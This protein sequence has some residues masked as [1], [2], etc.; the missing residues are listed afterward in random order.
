[1]KKSLAS[2]LFFVAAVGMIAYAMMMNPP[3]GVRGGAFIADQASMLRKFLFLAYTYVWPAVLSFCA[4]SMFQ[5]QFRLSSSGA[6]GRLVFSVCVLASGGMMLG[7]RMMSM[8]PSSTPSY[9]LG[10][11]LGYTM[12]SRLYAVRMKK[13][14]NV[15]LPWPIWRSDLAAVQEINRAMQARVVR[16]TMPNV[17]ANAA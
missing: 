4:I 11:A 10:M 8:G 7:L 1:M 9:V 3:G 15:R 2:N 14:W 6:N 17:P 13:V 12:M 5:L 16:P